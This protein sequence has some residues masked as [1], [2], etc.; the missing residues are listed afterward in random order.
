M[1][2]CTFP[3]EKPSLKRRT[4]VMWWESGAIRHMGRKRVWRLSGSWK[5]PP[6]P[7]FMVAKTPPPRFKLRVCPKKVKRG[8]LSLYACIR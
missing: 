4:S 1:G 5:R 6:Y 8:A 3:D 2:R 7:G